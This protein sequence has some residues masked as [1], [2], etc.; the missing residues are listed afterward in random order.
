[1]DA[2]VLNASW[3]GEIKHGKNISLKITGLQLEGCLF[4]GGRL[5]ESASNSPS[6]SALPPCYIAW[7]P[8]VML[9]YL[10]AI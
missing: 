9:F 4:E 3:S 2:L 5:S 10:F 6:V 8:Q 7:I 1:M